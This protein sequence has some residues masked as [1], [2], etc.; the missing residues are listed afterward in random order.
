M[1]AII[2]VVG[3]VCGVEGG[4]LAGLSSSYLD[5]VVSF[6]VVVAVVGPALELIQRHLR[7]SIIHHSPHLVEVGISHPHTAYNRPSARQW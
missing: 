3:G 1:V 6:V 7:I 4:V 2:M 5:E